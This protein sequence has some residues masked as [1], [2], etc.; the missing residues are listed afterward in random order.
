MDALFAILWTVGM[1]VTGT[2][3]G[4]LVADT[5]NHRRNAAGYELLY[6][7]IRAITKAVAHPGSDGPVP[8]ADPRYETALRDMGSDEDETP[9][10][11]DDDLAPEWLKV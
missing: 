4:F 6:Q 3:I 7:S 8:Q 1:L 9:S 5:W 10:Y 11:L 2:A